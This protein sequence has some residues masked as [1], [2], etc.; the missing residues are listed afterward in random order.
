MSHQVR[1]SKGRSLY[2]NA[3]QNLSFLTVNRCDMHRA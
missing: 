2:R 1:F 3:L